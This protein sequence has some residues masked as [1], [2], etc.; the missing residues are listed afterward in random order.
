MNN[1]S[2]AVIFQAF[3]PLVKLPRRP[4]TLARVIFP[5]TPPATPPRRL[6]PRPSH[7]GGSNLGVIKEDEPWSAK[8]KRT[9]VPLG[10]VPEESDEESDEKGLVLTLKS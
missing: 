2:V 8:E 5:L 6:S 10:L 9:Q 4:E 1:Q 3:P 7:G